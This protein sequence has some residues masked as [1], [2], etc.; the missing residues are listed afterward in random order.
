MNEPLPAPGPQ[1]STVSQAVLVGTIFSALSALGY[2]AANVFLRRLV[3][4]DPAWVATMKA[5]PTLM[6]T[7]P[8]L[9]LRR[10]QGKQ[11]K[12]NQQTVWILLAV[13]V[14]GHLAGNIGFQWSLGIVGLVV[15]VPVV[16]GAMLTST[17]LLGRW[18]LG[19][20]ASPRTILAMVVLLL[21]I[22]I[23]ALNAQQIGKGTDLPTVGTGTVAAAI[24]V[25]CLGG[26]AYTLLGIGIRHGLGQG[27]SL[28]A[29]L[30][31]VSSSGFAVLLGVS[32]QS[33]G[34][35]GMRATSAQAWLDMLLA[36]VFNAG[37]FLA[38]TRALQLTS[39]THVNLVN[40]SQVTLA[41]VAGVLLFGETPTTALVV[42][43]VMT[44][45]GLLMI[46]APRDQSPA[47]S[48]VSEA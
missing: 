1:A 9:W 25:L 40:A 36:G 18:L 13:A 15:A 45:A 35:S 10:R 17:P 28:P 23:L 24:L 33:L 7:I 37:A 26:V 8:W 20:S 11:E 29:C 31:I 22:G 44:I 21:A 38:L 32:F 46:Q 14:F 2:S 42:G 30:F 41:A 4:T 16:F 47:S 48:P 19:E 6:M 3:A 12:L 43:I 27:L 39:V 5:V 34:W